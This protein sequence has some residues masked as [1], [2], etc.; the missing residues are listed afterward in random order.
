MTT[1]ATHSADLAAD[2]AAATTV[3][4]AIEQE[5]LIRGHMPLV[6]H[7]VRDMLTRIPNHIHRDDLTS[8][9]LHALVTAA[10]S[11]DPDRGIPFHPV[12]RPDNG[13][14]R[15]VSRTV[16]TPPYGHPVPFTSGASGTPAQPPFRRPG[17]PTAR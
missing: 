9:G 12:T 5:E 17:R 16:G 4:S 13:P 1:F 3:L 15:A 2:T 11:W 8:A 10:R 6:G 7:L 14:V